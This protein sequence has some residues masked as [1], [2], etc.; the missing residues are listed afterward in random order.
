METVLLR[1]SREKSDL[2]SQMVSQLK[3]TSGETPLLTACRWERDGISKLD[4]VID[5]MIR[6]EIHQDSD[7]NFIGTDGFSALY[8]A[9]QQNKLENAKLLFPY[10]QPLQFSKQHDR[11]I[12]A[13]ALR[14][15][16]IEMKTFAYDMISSMADEYLSEK[17]EEIRISKAK[18]E[19][20]KSLIEDEEREK[21][22]E[23]KKRR[24]REKKKEQKA[25][26]KVRKQTQTSSSNPVSLNTPDFNKFG[27]D[28]PGRMKKLEETLFMNLVRPNVRSRSFRKRFFHLFRRNRSPKR[29]IKRMEYKSISHSIV[30]LHSVI[31]METPEPYVCGKTDIMMEELIVSSEKPKNLISWDIYQKRY[32]YQVQNR[33]YIPLMLRQSNEKESFFQY[34]NDDALGMFGK[35]IFFPRT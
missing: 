34:R 10:F 32:E 7:A 18:D 30:S 33:P 2:I 13:L 31:Q 6:H 3:K 8:Y 16:D 21:K 23:E 24:Q 26:A 4:L 29:I 11:D 15:E 12:I 5:F 27:G 14:Q 35:S 1:V 25:R 17:R 20:M 28:K 22:E 9:I 19:I